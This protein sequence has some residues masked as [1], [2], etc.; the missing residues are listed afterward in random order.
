[1]PRENAER[2]GRDRRS[3]FSASCERRKCFSGEM[4]GV[5]KFASLRNFSAI[6][7]RNLRLKF[8]ERRKT[9]LFAIPFANWWIG[10]L[11]RL[12][13]YFPRGKGKRFRHRHRRN[14]D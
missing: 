5:G 14:V 2:I 1:M 8:S 3:V 10:G 7:A 12:V 6:Q 4:E 9:L 13:K 11:A